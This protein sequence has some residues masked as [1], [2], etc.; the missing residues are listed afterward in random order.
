MAVCSYTTKARQ[1]RA[2]TLVAIGCP[3]V[4]VRA[5]LGVAERTW[6]TW[7]HSP[8]WLLLLR[9]AQREYERELKREIRRAA[10]QAAARIRKAGSAAEAMQLIHA[11]LDGQIADR[12]SDR[13]D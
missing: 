1:Q 12:L 5:T 11:V 8:D 4:R 6:Y 3:V 7:K 2:A 9:R 13:A 10:V